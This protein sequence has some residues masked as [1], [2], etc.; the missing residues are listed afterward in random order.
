MYSIY[1]NNK[2]I[3]FTSVVDNECDLE[4]L[5]GEGIDSAK[6]LQKV[7]NS[8]GVV[9]KADDPKAVFESFCKFFV[10]VNAAGGL[11][12]SSD[13]SVLMILR[14][15]RW[16]LPKGHH[17]QGETIEQCALREVAEECA[18]TDLQCKEL[19]TTTLHCYNIYGQWELKRTYWYAMYC[20]SKQAPLPQ[21]AEGIVLAQWVAAEDVQQKL[22][23]SYMTIQDVFNKAKT[24][25]SC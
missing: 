23:N 24:I 8:K 1:Y 13:G 14:N 5:P 7:D 19:I 11:V 6:V 18:I 17:E 4:V 15:G 3:I 10:P 20:P 2:V 16:D 21:Q 9:I 25:K 22:C 12:S